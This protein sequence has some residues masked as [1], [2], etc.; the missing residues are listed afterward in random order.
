MKSGHVACGKNTVTA[1]S[2][3]HSDILQSL[4]FVAHNSF[5]QTF[6]LP[7]FSADVYDTQF[8]LT[9]LHCNRSYVMWKL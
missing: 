3:I 2:F 7:R 1:L 5:Y 6:L 4:F 9:I 8:I